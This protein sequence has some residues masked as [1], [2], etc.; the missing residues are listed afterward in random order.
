MKTAVVISDT[1]GHKE[2]LAAIA[3]VLDEAD[4]IFHLG[5]GRFDMREIE[6]KYPEKTYSFKGNCDLC[7]GLREAE[8]EIEG[9]KILPATAICTA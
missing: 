9:V 5:D 4:Y 6:E 7:G 1:H 2:N 8:I 3:R